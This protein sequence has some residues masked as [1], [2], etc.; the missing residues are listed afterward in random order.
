[1]DSLRKPSRTT[2]VLNIAR[3]MPEAHDKSKSLLTVG[4]VADWLNVSGSLV[5]QLVEAKMIPVCRIG[6]GRGAIRF[7]PE[8]V[9]TYIDSCIDHRLPVKVAKPSRS[10]LKHVKVR[11]DA[12]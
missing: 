4:D 2:P 5:Y 10:R 1:M 6:N 11:R 7:R 8:D 3:Q 9:E 12:S